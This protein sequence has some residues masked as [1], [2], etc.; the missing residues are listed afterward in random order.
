M[1]TKEIKE[2]KAGQTGKGLLIEKDG[3]IEPQSEYNRKLVEE[4]KGLEGREWKVPEPF[5]VDA[6]LQKYDTPNA[7]NRIYPKEVLMKEVANY[8]EKYVKNR[9]SIGEADHPSCY[10]LS[11]NPLILTDKG[12]LPL[13]EDL[14]SDIRILTLDTTTREIKYRPLTRQIRSTYPCTHLVRF[15]SR[16]LNERVTPNHRFPIYSRS[17][18]FR[19][20]YTAED[21]LNHRV[22][23]QRHSYI[24]KSGFWNTKGNSTF[25]LSDGTEIPMDA[26]MK[27]LGIY[28][29][30]GCINKTRVNNCVYLFQKKP[31]VVE[32]IKELLQELP[33]EYS[34]TCSS[35]DGCYTFT[36]K[37]QA[38]HDYLRP[39]GDAYTK[40]VP[41]EMKQQSKENLQCLYDWFVL[42]DGRE[43]GNSSDIFSASKQLAL[44]LNEIQL[45]LG[46]SGTFREQ[47]PQDDRIIDCETGRMILK[48]NS[49][50]L[51]FSYKS[52][53]N[54]IYLD[55]RMLEVTLEQIPDEERDE[56]GNI[57]VGCVEVE[58]THNW[59]VMVNGKT[60]WTGNSSS[61]SSR[62]ISHDILEMHW[63]GKTLVGKL[64]LITSEGF[65]KMG[66]ISCMGDMIAN[67]IL[68]G[69]RIGVSSRGL[70]SVEERNGRLIVGD[71]YELICW[72]IVTQP[73]TP[74][75][76][77]GLSKDEIEPFI[78]AKEQDKN[79]D[80][81]ML[82]QLD[83]LINLIK[84]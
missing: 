34:S 28:L 20:F 3:Y 55:D 69:V 78:E 62:T 71:D 58:D 51:Y 50:K 25:T 45:K 2:I 21:I 17:G 1:E 10:P 56:D 81:T 5:I 73:S 13:A 42:G 36:I 43:R 48:E 30:E 47:E 29:A 35:V 26:W 15:R 12:W 64:R 65:R 33:F 70:G 52:L 37:H 57:E 59:F 82:E 14:P 8:D 38:L 75:A 32:L 19:G 76:W 44:D 27:F 67:L 39:L 22:P 66:I 83:S 54:G 6:V 23:D 63:E 53:S 49:S 79:D 74:N 84:G 60:H 72:D 11:D 4:V 41:N 40:Y 18:A 7:N 16:N 24:P 61:I 77:I 80:R 9:C 68:S 46:Y 31:E